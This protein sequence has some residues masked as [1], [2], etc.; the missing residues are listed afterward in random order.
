MVLIPD[1]AHFTPEGRRLLVSIDAIER[2]P[3]RVE[4]ERWLLKHQGPETEAT[5]AVRR[6]LGPFPDADL[7]ALAD[8]VKRTPWKGPLL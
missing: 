4:A 3:L 6:A 5:T 8:T 2:D 1:S 7:L